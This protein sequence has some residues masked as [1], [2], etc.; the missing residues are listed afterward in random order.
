MRFYFDRVK[1]NVNAAKLYSYEFFVAGIVSMVFYLKDDALEL[2]AFSKLLM[3]ICFGAC[4]VAS[5]IDVLIEIK[6]NNKCN[7]YDALRFVLSCVLCIL[8]F[9]FF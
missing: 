5:V 1:N 6:T 4:A 2:T 9:A 3:G 7:V 8:S